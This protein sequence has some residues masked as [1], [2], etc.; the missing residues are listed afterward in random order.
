MKIKNI[1][2]TMAITLLLLSGCG[3]GGSSGGDSSSFSN[4]GNAP[5][6]NN[7]EVEDTTTDEK[8]IIPIDGNDITISLKENSRD[9][10]TLKATDKTNVTYYLTGKDIK[11]LGIDPKTGY[12][13][14]HVAPD[15]EKKSKYEIF[16][17]VKDSVNNE[18]KQKVIINI[19]D[20]K[21]EKAPIVPINSNTML[22][23]DEEKYFITTWKTDNPGISN[24]NQI[25]IPT[26]GDGYNYS[27]DWGDGTSSKNLTVDAKHTY[28]H[29][30]IYTVKIAG[31][32]P[33]IYF[34]Q[35]ND[36]DISTYECD[37]RK[38]LSIDQWG[39]NI[40]HSMSGAFEETS[41]L[42]GRASDTPNLSKVTDMSSM[43]AL[44]SFNQNIND[45]DISNVTNLSFMFASSSFNQNIGSWDTSNVTDMTGLFMFSS[46]NKNINSWNTSKVERMTVMFFLNTTFNQDI[47]SWDTSNVKE[48]SLMFSIAKKFNQDISQWNTSNVETIL[49]MF[50]GATSFNQDISTWN[51]SK[52]K[53]MS[54]M[55][56][57]ASAFNQDLEQWNV[58]R[59]TTTTDIFTGADAMVI[60]PTWYLIDDDLNKKA[61]IVIVDNLEH[62]FCTAS[63]MKEL[64]VDNI[65]LN[66]IQFQKNIDKSTLIT[67]LKDEYKYCTEYGR[68]NDYVQCKSI[69][70][71]RVAS[72]CVVGFDFEK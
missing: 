25:I 32:F 41:N 48:M 45:W 43:F 10:F 46:F 1:V 11:D 66:T 57:L 56:Q 24:D 13:F 64:I 55:F 62:S 68:Q 28:A 44:S 34:G 63:K 19:T 17:G 2:C 36:Y 35:N 14:F 58:S 42:K 15:Y 52:V 21:N 38:I 16:V 20:I 65:F 47:G 30:G 31:K 6:L 72:E 7:I 67:S 29:A 60:L 12:T 3:G 26:V 27:V 33:R 18:T 54:Q 59:Y 49:G 70:F 5:V 40:W 23:E 50:L 61:F 22:K 8:L 69:D 51:V 4:E 71:Q 39:T 53:D 37:S 9:A